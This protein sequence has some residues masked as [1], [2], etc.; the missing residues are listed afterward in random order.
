MYSLPG[1]TGENMNDEDFKFSQPVHSGVFSKGS[2]TLGHST[3]P[4]VQRLGF[5][6]GTQH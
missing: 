4:G 6:N 3:G 5:S 1:K 2:K